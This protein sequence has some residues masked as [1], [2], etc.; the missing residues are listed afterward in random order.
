MVS[1]FEIVLLGKTLF[2]TLSQ[3]NAFFFLPETTPGTFFKI[4]FAKHLA[5]KVNFQITEVTKKALYSKVSK[6][7]QLPGFHLDSC[8]SPNNK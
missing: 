2:T 6:Q 3:I 8:S 7:E 1:P 5:N 4:H